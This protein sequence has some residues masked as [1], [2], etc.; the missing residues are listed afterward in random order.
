MPTYDYVCRAC[1]H[2]FEHFQKMTAGALRK[3]P[4]CGQL[5]LSR[6]LGSG[7]GII[8]RGSGF[9]ETDYKRK[10]SGNGRAS[11]GSSSSSGSSQSSETNKKPEEK[12]KDVKTG[13]KKD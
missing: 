9:Y 2:R 8:F 7:A 11:S 6:L 3:C 5:K 4:E 1:D 12:K 10:S 13:A